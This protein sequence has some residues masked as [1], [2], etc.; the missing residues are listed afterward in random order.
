[1]FR[2]EER[3][4]SLDKSVP[5]IEV[6]SQMAGA[7]IENAFEYFLSLPSRAVLALST[8]QYDDQEILQHCTYLV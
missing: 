7:A 4:A 2:W 3:L 6:V 1:M 5:D 8:I